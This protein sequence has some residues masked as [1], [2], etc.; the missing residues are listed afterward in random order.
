MPTETGTA[1]AERFIQEINGAF[2]ALSLLYGGGAGACAIVT[3]FM[4]ACVEHPEWAVGWLMTLRREGLPI[5]PGRSR[6]F[7]EALP[8]ATIEEVPA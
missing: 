4:E 2:G 6:M 8:L 3:A 7:I 1:N 5:D